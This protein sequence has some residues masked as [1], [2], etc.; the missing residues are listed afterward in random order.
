MSTPS[1]D[2]FPF[3]C[4]LSLSSSFQS[5]QTLH[6]VFFKSSWSVPATNVGGSKQGLQLPYGKCKVECPLSRHWHR[7]AMW[8]F[9]SLAGPWGK[10][11]VLYFMVNRAPCYSLSPLFLNQPHEVSGEIFLFPFSRWGS[12]SRRDVPRGTQLY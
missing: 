10:L 12:K 9:I 4:S 3:Y 11:H 8:H 2:I 6:K 7:P 5:R 1:L